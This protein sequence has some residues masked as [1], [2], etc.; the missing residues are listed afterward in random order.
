ML[1]LIFSISTVR[2]ALAFDVTESPVLSQK[3]HASSLEIPC[4]GQD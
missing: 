1:P 4:A 3:F 2:G